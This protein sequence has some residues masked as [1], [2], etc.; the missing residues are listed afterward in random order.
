M[1]KS[2]T[3]IVIFI[4]SLT[5]FIISLVMLKL[6]GAYEIEYGNGTLV[7]DCGWSMLLMNIV[8][9]AVLFVVSVVSGIRLYKTLKMDKE[10]KKTLIKVIV[11]FCAAI[12]AI[13]GIIAYNKNWLPF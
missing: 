3:D 7:V 8:R 13:V 9:L 1:K 6:Y 10:T 5:A 4:F 2:K 12:G 11:V